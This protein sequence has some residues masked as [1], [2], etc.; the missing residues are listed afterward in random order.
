MP[1]TETFR[2]RADDGTEH[3][4]T[5]FQSTVNTKDH[6]QHSSFLGLAT[7]RLANGF[8]LAQVDKNT[9]KIAKTGKML[10]RVEP[11]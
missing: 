3:Q 8:R 1:L 10:R 4:V 5:S 7:Y 6:D 11:I 9:F 2:V